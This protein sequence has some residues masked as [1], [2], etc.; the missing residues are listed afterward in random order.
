MKLSIS[1]QADEFQRNLRVQ[2]SKAR[3]RAEA[4]L[5]IKRTAEAR[6]KRSIASLPEVIGAGR[7]M[8]RE[9]EEMRSIVNKVSKPGPVSFMITERDASGKVKAFRV[10]PK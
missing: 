10:E 1:R 8:R 7:L 9:M 5:K 3:A 4:Q 6:K 2:A